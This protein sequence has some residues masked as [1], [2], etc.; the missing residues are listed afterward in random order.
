MCKNR[1]G[2]WKQDRLFEYL[3]GWQ[4]AR[5]CAADLVGVNAVTRLHIIF[6]DY[7]N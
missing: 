7:V 6:I 1:V 3:I 5:C 4:M 2:L